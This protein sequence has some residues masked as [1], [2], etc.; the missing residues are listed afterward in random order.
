MK[1]VDS[2]QER[3]G[4]LTIKREGLIGESG[5]N[6]EGLMGRGRELVER[7]GRQERDGGWWPQRDKDD[8]GE[9]ERRWAGGR[10]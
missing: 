7:R 4:I 5:M 8:D 3:V 6:R 10:K 9:K 1:R 2:K